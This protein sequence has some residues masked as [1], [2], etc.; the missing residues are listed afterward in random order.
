MG[1]TVGELFVEAFAAK[2]FRRAGEL[3][4][5]EVDFRALTPNRAW[6]AS[7]ADA[8][9]AV[10]AEWLEDSDHVDE[11]FGVETGG[12]AD[13]KRVTYRVRGSNDDGPFVFEQQAYYTEREGRIRLAADPLLGHAARLSRPGSL[14]AVFWLRVLAIAQLAILVR[15]HASLL[16]RDERNRLAALVAKSKGRP[17]HN[18]TANERGELLR[19][20]RSSSR[21]RSRT[22]SGARRAGSCAA[23]PARS[24]RGLPWR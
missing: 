5:P 11:L 13:R 2:D 7:S 23:R 1:Q 3:L 22:A 16:E 17:R 19:W 8:V 21:G 9:S 6:E 15:H 18:L 10:L 20:R 24:S 12:V 4:D 14:R